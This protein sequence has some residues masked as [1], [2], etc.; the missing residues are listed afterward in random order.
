MYYS[1]LT[2]LVD[3][4][5]VFNRSKFPPVF[6]CRSK[7]KLAC[8]SELPRGTSREIIAEIYPSH[9]RAE[10][11][12]QWAYAADPNVTSTA[13]SRFPHDIGLHIWRVRSEPYWGAR[14]LAYDA[15]D[16]GAK[17]QIYIYLALIHI[18]RG[19]RRGKCRTRW[20]P[21]E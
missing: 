13:T 6:M 16:G 20:S 15:S 10:C 7:L 5:K 17:A 2:A 8:E 1:S 3:P 18:R 21:Y 12:R 14:T 4:I 11:R 9:A 19:R